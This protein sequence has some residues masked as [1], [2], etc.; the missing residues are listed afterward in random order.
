MLLSR[1]CSIIGGSDIDFKDAVV[2]SIAALLHVTGVRSNTLMLLITCWL[3]SEREHK[4]LLLF[5]LRMGTNNITT[6]NFTKRTFW[7]YSLQSFFI[8]FVEIVEMKFCSV[9]LFRPPYTVITVN[10]SFIADF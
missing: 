8:M 6:T 5:T 2:C 7:N 4:T 3:W 9:L 1:N 10:N